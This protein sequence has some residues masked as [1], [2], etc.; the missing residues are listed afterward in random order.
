VL[1][2]IGRFQGEHGYQPS[3]REISVALAISH[4]RAHE[5][6]KALEYRGYIQR[7]PAK[8]RALEI[9]LQRPGTQGQP[10]PTYVPLVGEIAAGTPILAEEQV[11]RMVPLP[12]ELVGGGKTF[13]LR[14]SGNSMS[15]DGILDRDYVVV[16][17]QAVASEGEIVVALVED[18]A[19]VKRFSH[20]DGRVWLVPSNPAYAPIDGSHARIQG[21]VVS[22]LRSL[23]PLAH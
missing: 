11:E 15:R 16:R 4:S 8:P 20:R 23:N 9:N 7:N 10:W 18:G 12:P 5:L 22:V 19:T 21:K 3:I 1:Q 14:V 17:S 6:L 13:L 2:F